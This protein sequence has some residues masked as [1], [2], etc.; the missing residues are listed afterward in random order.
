MEGLSLQSWQI[1]KFV[2]RCLRVNFKL[3]IP[4][5]IDIEYHG[6]K[7]RKKGDGRFGLDDYLFMVMQ[8]GDPVR[9]ISV[10]K[11]IKQLHKL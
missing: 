10:Y 6:T 3:Y 2:D 5:Y 9:L 8:F 11:Y 7:R 1:S 4:S